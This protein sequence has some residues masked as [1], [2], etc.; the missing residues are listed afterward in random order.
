MPPLDAGPSARSKTLDNA[1][2]LIAALLVVAIVV[3]A[4]Y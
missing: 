4:R 1:L 3:V 2:S